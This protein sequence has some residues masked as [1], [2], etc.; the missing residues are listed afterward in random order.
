MTRSGETVSGSKERVFSQE[1]VLAIADHIWLLAIGP[2]AVALVAYLGV[3]QAPQQYRSSALLRIDRS[4]ARSMEAFVTSPPVANQI[5]SKY[6]ADGDTP[7]TRA[8]FLIQ[9]LRLTDP[10]PNTERPGDRLYRVDFDDSDPRRAQAIATD[11]IQTWLASTRPVGTARDFLEAELE[12]NKIAA[13]ANTK[14]L[15]D[16]QKET[17]KLVAPNSLSGE[18]AT[19]ISALITKRDQNLSAVNKLSDQ[20]KGITADVI[21]VPPH[22]PESAMPTRAG[23]IAVLFGVAALPVLLALVLLGRHVAPGLSPY[24][25]LLRGFRPAA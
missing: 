24:Q 25:V 11:S 21:L 7:E 23:A 4:A 19:P 20:L 9:H 18:L 16:L 13:A 2:I 6:G 3:S 12:R 14:L 22:L 10:E 15:D 8:M 5:L 1:L 17:T